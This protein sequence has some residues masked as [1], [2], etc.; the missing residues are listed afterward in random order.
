[1]GIAGCRIGDHGCGAVRTSS[2]DRKRVGMLAGV[3]CQLRG[4]AERSL[5]GL[6]YLAF[7]R[8]P[9]DAG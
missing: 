1:M 9:V 7:T 6:V 5:L 3:P 8:P 4:A 2:S